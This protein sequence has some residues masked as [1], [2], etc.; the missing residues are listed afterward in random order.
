[1]T[2]NEKIEAIRKELAEKKL[3]AYIVNTADPHMSEYITDYYKSREWIT[4]FTGSAGTAVITKDEALLWADGRYY[5]QAAEQ[6]SGSNFKL[7]KLGLADTPSITKWLKDNLKENAVV[8]V[9]G[10]VYSYLGVKQLKKEF[11][12]KKIKVSTEHDL[13]SP[14]WK[15][16]PPLPLGKTFILDIKYAGKSSKEKLSAVREK[17][18]EENADYYLV[19]SVDDVAWLYNVRGRDVAN[20]PVVISYALVEKDKAYFY[21]DEK[22]VTD[23]VRESFKQNNIEIRGY[24]DIFKDIGN[25]K[26]GKV[27]AFSGSKANDKLISAVPEGVEKLDIPDI[28]EK[29]KTIKNE[30]EIKNQYTAY[31]K[32]GVAL[33]KFFMWLEKELPSG[34]VTEKTAADKIHEYRTQDP[35]FIEE[36]FDSI[37]AFGAN[38]AMMHYNHDNGTPA[39]LEQRSF[40][41]LDS[42]GQYFFG[43]TDITR[44][45]SLGELT[46]EEKKDYTLTLQSVIRL[47]EMKFLEGT[48]GPMLDTISRAPMWKHGM[49]YKC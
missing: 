25:L 35:D 43:T 11:K 42:G 49:D 21:V 47:T 45:V 17:M 2:T 48:T 10:E 9:N 40:Y 6:I 3:D 41:L 20:N 27:L 13:I 46:E 1:M 4:G 5:I 22:K 38:A 30:T 18:A 7:M 44:T 36:S 32:D 26:K 34:K 37:S 14:I 12:R 31:V 39:T 8:G 33:T 29:L 24:E 23:E 15:D 28:T 16:R 19:A